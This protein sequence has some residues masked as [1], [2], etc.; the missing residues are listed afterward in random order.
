MSVVTALQ[1]QQR[2]KERVNV[3]LDGE[4]A[5]SLTLIEAVQL[6]KGQTLSEDEIATLRD[7]DAVNRAVDSAA[8]FLANRPRSTT[9]VRRNLAKK[10]TPETVIDQAIARLEQMGYLD[11][12]AF[13]RYW[14]ENRNTFKP[15]GPL[16]LRYE[17]RQ[18]GVPDSIIDA[19]LEDGLDVDAAAY[20]AAQ[21]KARRL[22]GLTRQQ[23]Q[24]KLGGFLQRRGFSYAVSRDVIEQIATEN[25]AEDPE[26]FV[27]PDPSDY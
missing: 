4:Y 21:Q 1:V 26:F 23:F 9:E 14:L 3:Y 15:R 12:T 22:R 18:K 11:D 27:E 8:R 5:F 24:N 20:K 2:N 16:A 13:A 7:S 10:D 17:L 6:H 19:V 25:T